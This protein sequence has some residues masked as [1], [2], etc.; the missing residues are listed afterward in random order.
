[1]EWVIALSGSFLCVPVLGTLAG[2][3]D[4][5]DSGVGV[6]GEGEGGGRKGEREEGGGEGFFHVTSKLIFSCSLFVS[7]H[8]SEHR[9]KLAV[10]EKKLA[11]LQKKQRVCTDCGG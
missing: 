6:E 3:G 7:L 10:T 4:C 1:M 11:A 8:C 5:C 2:L 9:R